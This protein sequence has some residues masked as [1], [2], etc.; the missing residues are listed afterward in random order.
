MESMAILLSG[1]S[2][3]NLGGLVPYCGVCE[4]YR[5]GCR[6][7]TPIDSAVAGGAP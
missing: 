6:H 7:I 5:L 4:V 2:V 3:G 1:H